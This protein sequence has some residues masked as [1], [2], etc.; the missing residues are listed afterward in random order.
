MDFV[1]LTNMVWAA[2]GGDVARSAD[3]VFDRDAARD[4]SIAKHQHGAIGG[5]DGW[6]GSV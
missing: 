5:A 3:S 4:F 2:L 1:T 6:S